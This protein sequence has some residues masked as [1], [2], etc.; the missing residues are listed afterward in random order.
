NRDTTRLD[1]YRHLTLRWVLD[2]YFRSEKLKLLLT[3]DCAHWGSPPRRTSFVFDSM[4][5]ISYFLGNYYPRGGSQ[6]FADELARAFEQRGGHVL[7]SSPVKRILV[8]NGAAC[9]VVVETGHVHDRR[10]Q[11][12]H[13][14]VVVSN[15]DLLLTA[16]RLLEPHQLPPEYLDSV[17]ALRP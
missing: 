7:L 16:E 12:V 15:A 14:D 6:A 8:R 11:K 10:E 9:G 3:A 13:A 1:P 17:R 4:L 5:R 2:R